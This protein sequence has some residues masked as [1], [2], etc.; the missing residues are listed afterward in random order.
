MKTNI[1]LWLLFN[2]AISSFAQNRVV[3]K[4]SREIISASGSTTSLDLKQ[5]KKDKQR[6]HLLS[7]SIPVKSVKGINDTLRYFNIN[8]ANTSLEIFGQDWILQW[9]IAPA[10]MAISSIGISIADMSDTNVQLEVK[11]VKLNWNKSDLQSIGEKHLGY[12]P[13]AGNGNNNITAFLDNPDRT[14][15]W[16]DVS[17]LGLTNPFAEDVWS[18]SGKGTIISPILKTAE[19]NYQWIQ[20][21]QS[22]SVVIVGKGEIV[23][24]A[25]RNLSPTTDS[26]RVRIS[27]GILN[28]YNGFKFYSNGR[29]QPGNDF[30]WWSRG[31]TF[32]FALAVDLGQS[33]M[34][35]PL[36][37]KLEPTLSTEPR[38]VL[39]IID[40]CGYDGKI[41]LNYSFDKGT[42]FA[43]SQMII[44]DSTDY[45]RTFKGTIPG[46]Q[47]GTQVYYYISST[48]ALGNKEDG[49]IASYYIF[50]PENPALIVFNGFTE[51][52]DYPQSYYFG[53]NG[54]TTTGSEIIKFPQDKW[55]YGKL[56][57]EL[58]D[59]YQNIFE[60]TT[61]GPE[62]NNN[63]VIKEWLAASP[64]HNYLLAG[65]DYLGTITNW[66]DTTYAPGDFQYDILGVSADHNDINYATAGDEKKASLAAAVAGTELGDSLYL[67]VLALNEDS[68]KIDP[69]YELGSTYSN[70][71]DGFETVDGTVVDVT[72]KGINGNTYNVGSH[73][74][75]PTGNKIVFLAFDPLSLIGAGSNPFWYGFDRVSPLVQ[76]MR[77]F[78]A[79]VVDVENENSIP[80]NF[81]LN[82][83][84]PNPF[85]PST[86]ISF[87]LS[88]KSK[89]SL[90]VYDVLGNEV[91]TLV[92][93]EKPAGNYKIDFKGNNLASGIYFYT[94]R[95]GSFVQSRKMILLK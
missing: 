80:L 46:A 93:E 42:T 49:S 30:G 5:E 89:V 70:W 69:T 26:T 76:A 34:F 11:L 2:C 32:D 16:V 50:K 25:I 21:N 73:R 84:Y 78:G 38:E 29:L 28:N 72:A 83:N 77:W 57:K 67:K 31:Y 64:T 86:V 88:V 6:K 19:Q 53:Y 59:N 56:T 12:Y 90:K 68:L 94:L 4:P 10:D 8:E 95:A 91:A 44:T 92:N 82:Q 7:N 40:Q 36:F 27:A 79:D 15:D 85:N 18:D 87:Q 24:V 1:I 14:G 51:V 41:E 33:C 48:D 61:T 17:G 35:I 60:I 13:A 9:F 54:A 45:S 58:V 43:Q 75:L 66:N 52:T 3:L 39:A 62:D 71:L 20:M 63:A 47:P 74:T 81:Q 37:T 22:N 23:G 65:D 55:A